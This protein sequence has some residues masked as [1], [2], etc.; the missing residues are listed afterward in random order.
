MLQRDVIYGPILSRRYGR[1]LG[2][3]LSPCRNKLCSFDC[4]YCH[5]GRTRRHTLDVA[6]HGAE[7]P[8]P[9]EVARKLAAALPR[10]G[11]L[12]LVTFSGNGEPTLHPAFP[13][14]VDV[15]V[16]L[17]DRHQPDARVALLSNATG[18][19]RPEVREALQ[20]LDLPILKL[21]AGTEETFHA[22]NAPAAGVDFQ[23]LVSLMAAQPHIYV[24]TVLLDGEPANTTSAELEAYG[25]LLRRIQP[26]EVHLHSIDRPVAHRTI[27]LVPAARLRELARRIGEQA[28][29]PVRAFSAGS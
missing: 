8:G 2:I 18:L 4:I 9:A 26:L 27:Q 13:E 10:A 16:S 3:N 20:R 25:R 5:Y 21:D 7:L 22:I 11:L 29:V 1:S 17:R 15:V 12:D 23:E 24:Q 6:E 28:G 14:I 19:L